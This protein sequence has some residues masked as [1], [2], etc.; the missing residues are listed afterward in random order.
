MTSE[1]NKIEGGCLCGDIRYESDAE[2]LKIGYCHCTMCQKSLG[3]IFGTSAFFKHEGFRF[4]QGEPRRYA[5]SESV[6]RAFC[7]RCGSPIYYQ[8]ED[9]GH[10]AIWLG[11]L[12]SP[13]RFK[14]QFHW[15]SDTRL[16][17]VDIQADLP[18]DTT[19][20]ASYRPAAEE[21]DER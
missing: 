13:E 4:N 1:Y 9:C 14:P 17:W 2:P 6:I 3:N 18:E 8:H 5:S 19:N 21:V 10:I 15:F 12:D 16:S 7:G 11:T 20:L